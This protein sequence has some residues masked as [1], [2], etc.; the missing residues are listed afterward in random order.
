[1][2]EKPVGVFG[3]AHGFD[4]DRVFSENDVSVLSRF[5]NLAVVA[6]QNARL[7]EKAQEEIEFRRRTEIELRNA[8]QLLQ[9]QVERV[10]LLQAQLKELAIR[11]S[12]TDLFN[13]RYLQEMLD[14]EFAR[15]KRSGTS[16]A[17]L[18]ID[19]DNLKD[20]NDKYG[21]KAGDDFLVHIANI[22]RSSVRAGD[23]ACRYGGDEFVVVLGNVTEDIAYVRA[24]RL[25]KSIA[26]HFI[27]Q[28]EDEKAS[29]SVSI[30]IA[31][32]PGHGS[33]GEALLQKAD[34]AL[35]EAKQMGKNS[36][37]IYKGQQR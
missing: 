3:V 8:N 20:I 13:R 36:V 11:D 23:I 10:E 1:L 33:S 34:Q 15:S 22:V 16:L 35:Y 18:M 9:L 19:S 6:L 25:R 27:I 4:N 31:M 17:I 37:V 5:A 12:L 7:Y 26:A 21:H 30:G 32:Y 14:V 29:V 24:E 28:R 2:K